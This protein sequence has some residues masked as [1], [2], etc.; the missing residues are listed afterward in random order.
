[1]THGC[2]VITAFD[3]RRA[4]TLHTYHT[5]MDI[6][7]AVEKAV[8]VLAESKSYLAQFLKEKTVGECLDNFRSNA[9]SDGLGYQPTVAG[10]V[11]C[12]SAN[13]LVPCPKAFQKDLP[14]WSGLDR[15]FR[16]KV[17]EW[18]WLLTDESGKTVL[19]LDPTVRLAELIVAIAI[20]RKPDNR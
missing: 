8:A 2:L 7:K 18:R 4:I 10:L 12:A 14:S 15:P 17:A 9:A 1:M 16:L 19:D 6:P 20:K 13:F 3:N 5:G 11:I